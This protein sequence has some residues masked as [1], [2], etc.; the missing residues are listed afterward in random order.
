MRIDFVKLL[1]SFGVKFFTGLAGFRA[2]LVNLLL[3]RLY[4]ALAQAWREAM[5]KLSDNKVLNEY[6]KEIAKP[7]PDIAKRDELE[8]DI[9][10]GKH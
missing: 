4:K 8:K 9:L 5:D 7:N 6:K 3:N 2:W 10:T 1:A